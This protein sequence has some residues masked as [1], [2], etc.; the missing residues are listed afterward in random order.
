MFKILLILYDSVRGGALADGV[1]WGGGHATL[2]ATR[3]KGYC[4]GKFFFYLLFKFTVAIFYNE[5]KNV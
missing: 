2:S 1:R 3:Y 4:H 5:I